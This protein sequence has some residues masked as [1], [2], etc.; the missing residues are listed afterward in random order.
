MTTAIPTKPSELEDFLNDNKKVGAWVKEG[1]TITDLAKAYAKSVEN[2]APQFGAELKA[3]VQRALAE[4]IK[5]NREKGTAPVDLRSDLNLG[6]RNSAVRNAAYNPQ[7]PGAKCDGTYTNI[8]DMAIDVM[9]SRREG[10]APVNSK[11]WQKVLEVTNA[12][13]END[14][15]TGGFLV[16]EEMRSELLQISLEQSV[17]RQRATV[18][19]MGS[20]STKIPFVDSTTNV[21]SVFG[22]MQ[23]YWVGESASI[24][25]TEA[26][27]GNVKL[28]A[29]KLVG[30]ARVPNELWADAPAL[31]T[32]LDVAAPMGINF[33][34]D[35]SFMNGNG[36]DQ[37]LGILNSEALIQFDRTTLDTLVPADIY[38]M[39]A[40]MLPQSLGSAVWL[41]NQT[42]LPKLFGMQTIVQ[43]VAGTENVGG[44]FPLGI[45]NIAGQPFMSLLGRPLIV[46][47]KI[48]ALANNGGNDIC[49]VDWKYYLVG[50]RQ[51]VSMDFSEHSRFMN[52]ETEMRIIE[53]VDGRPWVQSA[54]TPL[55]GDTVSPYIG[56]TDS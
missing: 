5:E 22:G 4:Y 39:Y 46:T 23:F 47:E 34:E 42:L 21:G 32:W 16:P 14:P 12:Y 49:F 18:I 41:V 55:N 43:N 54:L 37:P 52:D 24:T 25:P 35:N 9:R 50:D 13:S 8:G 48:P 20:L 40:R 56:I 51:A 19:T 11:A 10:N 33:Y 26:K 45:M 7:A 1:G 53:R 27:F 17:V 2:A 3:E 38:G 36:A 44:G 31:R 6:P 29:N 30:G 15:S 28:E